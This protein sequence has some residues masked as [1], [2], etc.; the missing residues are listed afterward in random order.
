MKKTKIE[1]NNFSAKTQ[2]TN[3]E[4]KEAMIVAGMSEK[5]ANK[6]L[7]QAANIAKISGKATVTVL[8][9]MK[10]QQNIGNN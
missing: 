3:E 7:E 10:N 9:E 6:I 5:F 2:Y 4:I 1:R 8:R